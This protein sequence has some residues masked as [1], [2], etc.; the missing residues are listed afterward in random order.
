MCA[1]HLGNARLS[2]LNNCSGAEVLEENNYYPFGLK[3]GGYNALAG[4]AEYKY[5]GK[6]LQESTMYDFGWRQYMPELGRWSQ[7]DP[8]AE[9]ARALSPYRYSFNNPLRFIDSD[10]LWEIELRLKEAKNGKSEMVLTFVAQD[11]DNMDT[12]AEQTGID[13]SILIKGLV[14]IDIKAGTAL[15]KLG[16]KDADRMIEKINK[17]I[18]DQGRDDE[19]NCW[20]TAI[21]MALFGTVRFDMDKNQNNEPT[22]TIGDPNNADDILQTKFRQTDKPKFGDV[23]RYAYKDGNARFKDSNYNIVKNGAQ[24]GGTSHYATFLLDN[25]AGTIYVFSKNGAGE[26]GKWTVVKDKQL[27]GDRG[28]GVP[29][30][31][32]KGSPN[33]TKK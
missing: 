33:Y 26:D 11:G 8:L 4:N 16:V 21:S 6:E 32:G 30:P 17:Y 14:G 2:Y 31:I 15:E 3:H 29:M 12:L 18:N 13:K 28:Y 7:I 25:G 1:D 24:A 10:G 19:S 20:G 23:S 22:G 27:L 5:G 9:K